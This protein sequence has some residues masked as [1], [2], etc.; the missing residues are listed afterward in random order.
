MNDDIAFSFNDV[1]L[2]VGSYPLLEHLSFH[3][4]KKSF[5]LIRG[6]N[7]A[8]KTT[9]AKAI[10]GLIKP[11]SGTIHRYYKKAAYVPQA[12]YLDMQYPLSLFKLMTLGL[13]N[14]SFLCL[15]KKHKNILHSIEQ[16]TLALCDI[17]QITNPKKVLFREA[18][19][20]QLQ[21]ALIGAALLTKPDL[22]IL[23]EP[24]SNLDHSSFLI[25]SEILHRLSKEEGVSICIIDHPY[26]TNTL[27]YNYSLYIDKGHIHLLSGCSNSTHQFT[28]SL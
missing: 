23:D 9:L 26:P 14:H 21:K 22:I 12:S 27:E 7:G 19:G 2:K 11:A 10:L 28:E 16:E 5:C 15:G 1:T 24:F 17:L 13:H 25:V 18:S 8:G 20:G 4:H 3:I 6:S